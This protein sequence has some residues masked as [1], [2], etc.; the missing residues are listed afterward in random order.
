MNEDLDNIQQQYLGFLKTPALW[1]ASTIWGIYQFEWT[2]NP[3][4]IFNRSLPRNLRLG[5]RVEQFMFN[6]LEQNEAISVLAENV[7]IQ[8][9]KQTIGEIDGIIKCNENLIHLEIVYKFYVY[10]DSVG[11]SET[12]H[13]IGPNRKDSLIEK[14]TKL[15][16]KQLPLLYKPQTQV[17]IES[18]KLDINQILQNVCFKAQLFLPYNIQVTL[19]EL[20][21][22]CIVGVY[23]RKEQLSEFEACEFYFPSK[24][25]WLLQ[26]HKAVNWQDFKAFQA[27]I[28]NILTEKQ[29]ACCWI[30]Q[31][32]NTI[33]KSFIVWW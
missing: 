18:L 14:L 20:N 21:T 6:E 27:D 5:K 19:K 12:E 13:F 33:I 10:D 9:R 25:N 4:P 2:K 7:Q 29:S 31:A 22:D 24:P 17:L 30:K 3:L 23:I 8:N 15:K 28:N 1:S 11:I 16:N 26:P 32:D